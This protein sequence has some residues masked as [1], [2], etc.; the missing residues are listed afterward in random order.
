MSSGA[1]LSA[2]FSHLRLGD[3][4]DDVVHEGKRLIIDTLGCIVGSAR[5]AILP[6]ID[7]GAAAFGG[8]DDAALIGRPGRTSILQ[9]AYVNGRLANATDYDETFPV[10]V[11]LGAGAVVGGFAV[12]EKESL[13]GAELLLATIVGY[14]IGARLCSALAPMF[15]PTGGPQPSA[16]PNVWAVAAPVVLA[17]AGA[18][19]AATKLKPTAFQHAL[20]LATSNAPLLTGSQWSPVVEIPNSKYC[21]A[22]W[23]CVSGVLGAVLANSGTTGFPAILDG[24]NSITRMFGSRDGAQEHHFFDGL[25]EKWLLRDITYKPWPTCKFT[26]HPMTA[27]ER[28][29]LEHQFD[30]RKVERIIV[31]A[32]PFVQSGRFRQPDPKTFVSRQFSFPHIIALQLLG[33]P[34]GPSWQD[35]SWNANP[36]YL[37]LRS[38]VEVTTHPRSHGYDKDFVD[39]Q[40]RRLPAGVR[41]FYDGKEYYAET[42][43]AYGDPWDDGTYFSDDAI[44]RKFM[45]LA[46]TTEASAIIE[47]L[48]RLEELQ[49]LTSVTQQL[50]GASGAT[51]TP[52]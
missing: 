23:C 41:V 49:N 7:A 34:P 35:E 33:E 29:R 38:K 27:L 31:E 48:R 45:R 50:A 26:H 15:A 30:L 18:A 20:A 8:G 16:Y 17:A 42:D 51:N 39:N 32:A 11:H 22:G 43:Y 10:G 13:T 4:P 46:D 37:T 52:N 47:N 24:D 25:G 12:A 44:D 36:T 5:T 1:Q 40:V 2:Y 6:V 28:L 19:A 3:V 14:E 9:A 21:D